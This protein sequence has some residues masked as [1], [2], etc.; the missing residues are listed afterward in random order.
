MHPPT[1]VEVPRSTTRPGSVT[2]TRRSGFSIE[3][4]KVAK[5]TT[6]SGMRER[7]A[8]RL[9]W[10]A[11]GCIIFLVV[12]LAFSVE[13]GSGVDVFAFTSL[14]FP[15]VGALIAARQPRALG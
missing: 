8:A 5:P 12:A 11:L 1:L 2:L 10:V 4:I 13:A 15:V 3:A 14:C 9:A 6:G 7:K